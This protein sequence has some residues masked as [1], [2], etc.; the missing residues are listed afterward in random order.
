MLIIL[1]LKNEQ[2]EYKTE[3]Y[4]NYESLETH[5]KESSEMW[6][7]KALKSSDK[8][9]VLEMQAYCIQ[10]ACTCVREMTMHYVI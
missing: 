7:L 10:I 6:P 3:K 1:E 5:Q 2:I 9:N 4:A 8:Q